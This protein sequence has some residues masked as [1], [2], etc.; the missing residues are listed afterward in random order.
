[1]H[2]TKIVLFVEKDF[3]VSLAKSN[4]EKEKLAQECVI[5]NGEALKQNKIEL[6]MD[7]QNIRLIDV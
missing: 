2:F 1:M 7:L 6:K 3:I 5:I 4:T